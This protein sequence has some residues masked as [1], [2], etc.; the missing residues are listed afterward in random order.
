MVT[1]FYFYCEDGSDNSP[2]NCHPVNGCFWG[3]NNFFNMV[4]KFLELT[5]YEDGPFVIYCYPPEK[6]LKDPTHRARPLDK[7]GIKFLE[8]IFSQTLISSK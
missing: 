2:Y 7:A 4:K 8:K 5:V 6:I 1:I 3:F